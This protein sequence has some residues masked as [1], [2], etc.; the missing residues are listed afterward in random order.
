[1]TKQIATTLTIRIGRKSYPIG[2]YADASRMVCK[3]RDKS[4]VGSSRFSDPLIYEGDRA[5]AYVSYNGRVWAGSPRDW[6]PDRTPLCEAVYDDAP[7]LVA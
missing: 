4:G 6:T 3:A 5:V 2:N 1:M 7:S